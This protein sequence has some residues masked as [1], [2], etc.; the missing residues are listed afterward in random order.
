MSDNVRSNADGCH[1]VPS[2]Q[3]LIEGKQ[4][5]PLSDDAVRPILSGGRPVIKVP[6]V[7]AETELQIVV[8]AD[9]DF[10]DDPVEIKRVHKNVVLTQCKLVPVRFLPRSLNPRTRVATRAKLFVEGYIRKNIE[11]VSGLC[12]SNLKDRVVKIPFHGFA[13][14]DRDEFITFPLFGVTTDG[15]SDFINPKNGEFPRQDKYFF[16]NSVYYNEQPYCEL[17]NAN[18]YELD[19]SPTLTAIDEQYS[20]LREKIV[21]DLTLKV[22]QLRQVRVEALRGFGLPGGPF[23]DD[24]DGEIL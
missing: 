9:V 22:L 15:R 20:T 6:H 17:V 23:E 10:D 19:F 13:E 16:E 12:E 11:Y 7:L 3:C 2:D 5:I 4:Q 24:E 1:P 21:L 18:F 8:E 14:I